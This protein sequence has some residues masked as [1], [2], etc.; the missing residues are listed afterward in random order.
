MRMILFNGTTTNSTNPVPQCYTGSSL[1]S[2]YV[3]SYDSQQ[4]SPAKAS[5]LIYSGEAS[6]FSSIC[7]DEVAG[8]YRFNLT[9]VGPS[10]AIL[11][12]TNAVC[13][14]IGNKTGIIENQGIPSTVLGSVD[15]R[16][17]SRLFMSL[18]YDRIKIDGAGRIG[19]GSHR[20]CI[21]R[22]GTEV[23]RAVVTVRVC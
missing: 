16:G 20:L 9:T 13:T 22:N 7:N 4:F 21:E 10:Q 11:P 17:T 3:C 15:V 18:S 1:T 5:G 19:Q 2:K 12:F 14:D 6:L 8:Q 23:D